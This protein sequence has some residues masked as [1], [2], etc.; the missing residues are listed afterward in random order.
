MGG[1]A[2]L[3]ERKLAELAGHQ[4][5]L[6]TLDQCAGLALSYNYI[7][8]RLKVGTWQRLHRGVFKTSSARITNE[9]RE[10]AALLAAGL[11]CSRRFCASTRN[12]TPF[13]TTRWSQSAWN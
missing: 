5:G 13:Q 2:E 12:V 8:R 7:E 10:M 11:R 9:E 4:L 3:I 6:V 1:V